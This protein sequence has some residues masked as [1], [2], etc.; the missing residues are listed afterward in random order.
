MDNVL[1]T[2]MHATR[3]AVNNTMKKSPGAL[4]FRQDMFVDVPII[5]DLIAVRNNRQQ[6]TD[7]NL[8]QHNR[9]QYNYHYR[10][11]QRVV[12]KTY[13]PVKME[14]RLHGPYPILE[15]RINGTVR[16]QRG[17]HIVETFDLWKIVP[18]KG[19]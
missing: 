14:E 12:V 16:I 19:A 18:Y 10:M 3:C 6:L 11:G 4:T 1:A 8:I 9:K 17:P 7:F 5:A 15:F 13:D 2:V